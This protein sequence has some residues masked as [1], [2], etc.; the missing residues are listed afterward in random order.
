MRVSIPLRDL[1]L[2]PAVW[3]ALIGLYLCRPVAGLMAL[4]AFGGFVIAQHW[5]RLGLHR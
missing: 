2:A 3:F 1:F 5:P 4:S